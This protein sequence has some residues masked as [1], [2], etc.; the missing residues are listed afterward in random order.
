MYE[1]YPDTWALA[2]A[3]QGVPERPRRRPRKE[4]SVL[5]PVLARQVGAAEQ[6]HVSG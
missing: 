2:A 4:H 5:P 3:Q 1:M 6:R